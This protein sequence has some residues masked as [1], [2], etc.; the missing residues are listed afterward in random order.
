[1]TRLTTA[2]TDRAI[3]AVLGTAA[4]DALGAGYEFGPPLADDA[5]VSMI[6]GGG[7]RWAPGEWTDDTSMAVPILR[8]VAEGRDLADEAT[9]DDIVAAWVGWA[10]TAPDVGIQTRRALG[11]L[12]AGRETAAAA[13]ASARAV[14]DESGRSGG[15]GSLMRTAPV[16]LAYLGDGQESELA[17]AAR[18][19][20]D[21]THFE[22]DAG[23]ACV[24]W[25]LAIRHAIRT[26]ELDPAV[27]LQSLP[28]DRR[29]RWASLINEAE[30]KQP[31]D[32]RSNGWVV[33]ALQAAWCSIH[34]AR[35]S[36]GGLVDALERAVRG[37]R[38]TDTVAA[39]AGALVGAAR[40]ASGIPFR[41]T[42]ILHGWPGLAA[43]DLTRLAILATR[44]GKADSNGWPTDTRFDYSGWGDI[45]VLVPHPHD[46]GVLL[47][48][49]GVLDDLPGEVDA[50]VSLCRLGAHHVPERILA[51]D[52]H[53]VWLVDTANSVD[54]PH[55]DEV[56]TDA[57][58]TVAALRAEGKTVLLHCVQAQS[59][60][61][62]VGAL[63]SA[64]Y[65]GVPAEVAWSEVVAALPAARPNR[66]FRS[67]Y[68]RL[69]R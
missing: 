57:A 20:S 9:L 65:R 12:A 47:G 14:H 62:T 27:G 22:M 6:G 16:A 37:G 48:A 38:D 13:R 68:E 63:Y 7:F 24:L 18:A 67:A 26:G 45:R 28:E 69:T 25:C 44:G 60:T 4:G 40:G 64:L 21:L 53:R 33:E 41:W 42:R 2:Q 50:V 55:L 29:E 46:P 61:P 58:E 66:A 8:A 1:M 36:G 56:L 17:A 23:D 31:R 5:P 35:E 39:I 32:F 51:A 11:A 3:G 19:V 15:N 59:R 30:A 52:Q 49:V 10:R 43:S 54:N 34:R